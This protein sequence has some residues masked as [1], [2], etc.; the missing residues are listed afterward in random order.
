MLLPQIP[1]P[2]S[3]S[4][5]MVKN[6]QSVIAN[7]IPAPINHHNGV[8]RVSAIEL[9]LSVTDANVSPLPTTDGGEIVVS[10]D[11]DSCL[12]SD[13]AQPSISGFGFLTAAR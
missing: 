1:T 10:G 2:T 5:P 9:I 7:E 12:S 3:T 6:N 13:I 11:Q 4:L 8:R